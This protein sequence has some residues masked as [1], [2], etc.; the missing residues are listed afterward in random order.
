MKLNS[1]FGLLND[2][3]YAIGVAILSTIKELIEKP[4]LLFHPR[5]L[6]HLFMSHVWNFFACHIDEGGKFVKRMLITPN[7]YGVV[8]DIG[9]GSKI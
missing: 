7:A 3:R 6:S 2:L 1:T 4:Y 8:L 5:L 9:A